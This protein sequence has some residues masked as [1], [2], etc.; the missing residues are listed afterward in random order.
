[1]FKNYLKIAIRNLFKNKGFS[2]INILG[3]AIGITCCVLILLFVQDELSFDSFHTKADRLYRLNKIVTPQTGGT[4]LHAIT[5]GLMGPTMVND[6]PEV[7][8]CVRLLPWFSDVLMSHG[9]LTLKVSDVV[10]ADSNFFEVFDFKLLHG[11]LETALVAPSSLILAEETARKFFGDT[12]PIGQI[13][14]GLGDEQYTVTGIIEEAPGNSHLN[15]NAL[16]SW[17]TT[18]PGTGPLGFAWLNRWITQVNLTYLL[19]A[20]GVNKDA[21][22][23]K[24]PDFMQKYMPE[25]TEQYQLYLQPFSKIYL[26]SSDLRFSDRLRLGNVTYV[27]VFSAIALLSLLIA[28]INFTNLSTARATKRAKEVGVRKVLGAYRR[29]LARQF[30]GESMLL[31]FLALL[32]AIVF[33]ELALPYFNSFTQKD[34]QFEILRNPFLLLGLLGITIFVGL[35]SGLYPALFLSGFRP[36]T[37]LKGVWKGDGKGATPRKILVILQFSI[38][39]VLIAA[40]VVVFQQMDFMQKTSLGF[41]KEQIVVLPIGKA[42]ISDRFQAFKNELLQHPNITHA[43]GSNSVPGIGMM[44]FGL[45]PEGKPESED[46]IAYAMRIDDYDFLETYGIEMASGRYFSP[47]YSTDATNGVIINESLANS[48]GWENPVGKRLDISGE[49][50]EGT[51][52]GVIKDYHTRSLHHAI[53]PMVIYFAPRWEHLSLRI[54]G[55]GI[56]ATIKFV[57]ERW[58]AFESAYPFEYFFLDRK[59]AEFYQSEERLMQTF[60]IFSILAIFIACLGLFGLAAYTSEQRTKE[61]GIRKV[62]G[63]SIA[64]MVFLISKDFAKLVV[65]AFVVAAPIAFILMNRWLQDFSYRTSLGADVF[66]FAGILAFAIA[67]LTVSYQ[68]IKTALLNPVDSLRYE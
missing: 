2:F 36:V 4:E 28:C 13:M 25:K 63:A 55:Q 34:L 24:L 65:I 37:V 10:I 6:Y 41:Q 56:P 20:P 15:Y 7:E 47:D 18:V 59:F 23:M 21:L 32:S 16:I 67:C 3:L 64:N 31:S 26:H 57:K 40:T 33:V 17:S 12:D 58:E 14:K 49:L 61:I 8:Q 68:A 35:T 50:D 11:D 30:F 44:S 46:W 27:Y 53:D 5:S 22:E 39:I 19:L 60:G 38:S 42:G 43:A 52:I 51:V 54:T 62:L 29:Q 45:R 48:L 66:I 1:M 9:E